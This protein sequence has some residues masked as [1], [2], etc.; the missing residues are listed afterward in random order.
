MVAYFGCTTVGA[1]LE[2]NEQNPSHFER[3]T[4]GNEAMTPDLLSGA[5][6]SIF[7]FSVL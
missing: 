6:F 4:F 1:P 3:T 5:S 2:N 7:T